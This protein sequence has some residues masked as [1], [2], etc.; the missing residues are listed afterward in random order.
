MHQRRGSQEELAEM[1]SDAI[2]Q[3]DVEIANLRALIT[4]LRPTAL[5]DLGLEA[6]LEDLAGRARHRGLQVD[7]QVE[8]DGSRGG[9]RDADAAD[10]ETAIYR[11]AQEA[12]TNAGKHGHAEH[13]Q[14]AINDTDGAITVTIADNGAGFDPAV[15]TRGFGL[16]GMRERVGLLYGTLDVESA[17]GEGTTVTARFPKLQEARASSG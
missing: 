3:L 5:D 15:R 8:V 6:A 17:P 2:D 11:I 13:V 12:L 4:E 14:I 16:A 1:M 9:D 10:L 7:L